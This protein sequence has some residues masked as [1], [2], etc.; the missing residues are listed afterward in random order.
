MGMTYIER[1]HILSYNKYQDAMET[2]KTPLHPGG[3]E[4]IREIPQASLPEGTIAD[5]NLNP[6]LYDDDGDESNSEGEHK[7]QQADD[8]NGT[9]SSLITGNEG[10][11]KEDYYEIEPLTCSFEEVIDNLTKE[12]YA[13]ADQVRE[14]F[15]KSRLINYIDEQFLIIQ[16]N[17]KRSRSSVTESYSLLTLLSDLSK[18]ID[19]IWHSV[20]TYSGLFGQDD[21][22]VRILG[23]LEDYVYPY[24]LFEDSSDLDALKQQL[25]HYFQFFQR[26]DTILSLLIDG[27]PQE[28]NG[29]RLKLYAT[30]VVRINS[31]MG[32]L[33]P[34]VISK[35]TSLKNQ[36][37]YESHIYAQKGEKESYRKVNNLSNTLD[38]EIGKVFE[39][40]LD[41]T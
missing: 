25:Q 15:Q 14:D 2:P 39:G 4:E 24:T 27:V 36:L 20:N 31:I 12:V 29:P 7:K 38:V 41:R 32:R 16:R 10:I 22:L 18:L 40:I 34:L 19:I 30:Q 17:Y 23:D 9:E 1:E 13:R 11:G 6:G 37:S 28:A 21:C 8:D 35:V 33:R 3:D 5:L 26:L